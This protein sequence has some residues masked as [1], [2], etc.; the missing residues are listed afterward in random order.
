MVDST[1]ELFD[2]LESDNRHARA[3]AAIQLG[4][5]GVTKAL[6][7]IRP[8]VSDSDD[9][10]AFAAMYACWLLGEDR[11]S[12]DRLVMALDSEDEEVIQQVAQTITAIGDFLVP[13]LEALIKQSPKMAIH[14]LNLLEEIGGPTALTAIKSVE[15]N[16]QEVTELINEIVEDWDYDSVRELD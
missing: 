6:P 2:L 12:I 4:Q 14:S 5:S 9:I 3:V 10:I 15:S 7:Q 16:D 13:K 11:I 1:A 8:L